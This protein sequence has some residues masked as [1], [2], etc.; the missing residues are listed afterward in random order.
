MFRLVDVQPRTVNEVNAGSTVAAAVVTWMLD[1]FLVPAWTAATAG[2][3]RY[4][5]P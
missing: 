3:S 5:S 1:D 4:A 2:C